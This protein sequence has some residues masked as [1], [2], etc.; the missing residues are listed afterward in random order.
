[1]RLV[2]VVGASPGIGK[3]L[4]CTS[5]SELLAGSGSTVEHFAEEDVLT[6][7]AF[8]RVAADFATTGKVGADLLVEAS[9]DYLAGASAAGAD[10]VVMD[11]LIRFVPSLLAFGHD[12]A[13]IAEIVNRLAER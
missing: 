8:A 6:H 10:I 11:S 13:E 3:S 7:P 5:L 12:E 2:A 1:M 4:L 9:V